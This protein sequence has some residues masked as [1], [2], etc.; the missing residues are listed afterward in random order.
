VSPDGFFAFFLLVLQALFLALVQDLFASLGLFLDVLAVF[1]GHLFLLGFAE[2]FG[3]VG[4]G[5]RGLEL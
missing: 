5:F 4:Q 1:V 2:L 3:G